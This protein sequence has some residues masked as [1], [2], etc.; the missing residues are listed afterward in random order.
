MLKTATRI[1]QVESQ[2]VV[3]SAH[4]DQTVYE[5]VSAQNC[6]LHRSNKFC[7]L[8]AKN[9]HVHVLLYGVK[10]NGEIDI[11]QF[12]FTRCVVYFLE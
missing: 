1:E 4:W 10:F 11:V 9:S 12:I 2:S 7:L 6:T 3:P 5:A 8:T